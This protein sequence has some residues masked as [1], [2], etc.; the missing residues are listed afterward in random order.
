MIRPTRIDIASIGRDEYR[1][2]WLTFDLSLCV[3]LNRQL[4][5]D[6][7]SQLAEHCGITSPLLRA[8]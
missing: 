7:V 2:A 1:R 8:R 4:A 3:E 6:M 5:Q